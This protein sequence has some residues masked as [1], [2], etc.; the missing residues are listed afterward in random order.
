MGGFLKKRII[1]NFTRTTDER[2]IR[3]TRKIKKRIR[4]KK[5]KKIK[6]VRIN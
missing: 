4:R 6:R 1:K 3:V 5:E 2:K